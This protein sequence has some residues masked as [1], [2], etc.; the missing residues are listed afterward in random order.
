MTPALRFQTTLD[1]LIADSDR[2]VRLQAARCVGRLPGPAVVARLREL[3]EDPDAQVRREALATLAER[4]PLAGRDTLRRAFNDDLDVDC[5]R[6][7]LKGLVK[8]GDSAALPALR[9]VIRNPDAF[10]YETSSRL[11][12]VRH[13]LCCEAVRA[14]ASV[15]DASVVPD[16]EALLTD[17]I[18]PE[19]DDVVIRT[20]AHLG[21]RGCAAIAMLAREAPTHRARSAVAALADCPDAGQTHALT[22]F[23][24]H[25]EESVRVAAASHLAE[26]APS[27][28]ALLRRARDPSPA[29]RAIVAEHAGPTMPAVLEGLLDDPDPEVV[30]AAIGA[31]CRL[32]AADC[33]PQL[34]W[35]LRRKLRCG[36]VAI[37]CRAAAAL[38][39]LDPEAARSDLADRLRDPLAPAPLRLTAAALLADL[40]GSSVIPLLAG[41]LFSS[42]DDLRRGVLET[43][44]GLARTRRDGAKAARVL[45]DVLAADGR[46][47]SPQRAS[48]PRRGS[49]ALARRSTP[50]IATPW[51]DTAPAPLRT[52][53]RIEIAERLGEI[54]DAA[55]AQALHQVSAGAADPVLRAAAAVSLARVI[56]NTGDAPAE[57]LSLAGGLAAE[58]CARLRLAGLRML[59]ATRDPAHARTILGG[60]D[61]PEPALRARAARWIGDTATPL[62][63]KVLGRLEELLGD[64]DPAVR[65]AAIGAL[66]RRCG[67]TCVAVIIDAVL[68]RGDEAVP[69]VARDLHR[70]QPDAVRN[71]LARRLARASSRDRQLALLRLSDA[72][73]AAGATTA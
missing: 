10:I 36:H 9:R 16:L 38:A 28:S 33:A 26:L 47:M 71:E 72:V 50:D 56:E 58:P 69:A 40:G 42:D 31:L 65:L 21:E 48:R 37:A 12:R 43:L 54:T 51:L 23:L 13:A 18:S 46:A 25:E 45:A 19:L 60:L 22:L 32:R 8:L 7:A 63:T 5:R 61:D 64:G 53:L 27:H 17:H 57:I 14:L 6:T 30:Y 39:I 49:A 52:R 1:R 35:T 20:L 3:A 68:A 4:S 73:L 11:Q 66:L 55:V 29:V 59:A 15:G 67:E 62:D 41:M 24:N 2:D 34:G 44:V 70:F